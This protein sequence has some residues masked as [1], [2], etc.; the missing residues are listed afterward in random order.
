MHRRMFTTLVL[1]TFGSACVPTDPDLHAFDGCLAN[2]AII[3]RAANATGAPI[4]ALDAGVMRDTSTCGAELL[5]FDGT[6]LRHRNRTGAA[7]YHFDGTLLRAATAS[8]ARL[9]YR[10]GQTWR[11]L[12]P[13]GAALF[14]FDGTRL[15]HRNATGAVIAYFDQASPSWAAIAVLEAEGLVPS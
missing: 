7:I 13:T 14:H 5:A 8:G 10:D 15:R 2:S 12:G 11:A 3:V 9:L 6:Y 4:Y 1:A